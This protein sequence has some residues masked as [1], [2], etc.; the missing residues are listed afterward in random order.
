MIQQII[1]ALVAVVAFGIA[2]KKYLSVYRNIK[3]GKEEKITGD[4]GKRINNT[5]LIALGQK[6]MFKRPLAATMHMFIYVAFIF[7]QIELVE[8]F[9]DGLAGQHRFFYDYLGGFYTL[10]ISFI[11]ILSL[12]ALIATFTFLARRNLLKLPRFVKPEME[13]WPKLDGNLILY[14]EFLLVMFIFLMNSSDMAHHS[15][16]YGFVISNFTYPLFENFS[17]STLHILE[18]IGWW[19]HILIVFAFLNYLPFSKHLHI[20]LA[21]P[22]TYFAKLEKKG[23]MENMPEVQ[24]EVASMF[25]PNAAF[26]EPDLDAPIPKFGASDIFDLSWRH[27][28]GAYTC[29]ECGRCTSMC[30]ANLTGKKLSPRKIMMDTRDRMEEVGKNIETNKTEFIRDDQKE[31]T[32]VLSKENYDDGKN[33]FDYITEE[34]LRACTTCN[35][36]V[37]ACPVMINPLDIIIELRRNLI[38]EQSKSPEEWNSMFNTIENNGAP[39]AFSPDDRDKWIV[40]LLQNEN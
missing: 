2:F 9:V 23:E 35:A 37:E 18:R 19:G 11:E 40:D 28:L 36:C 33:L 38:L 3:L 39:W 14:A 17:D 6:K 5:I 25:D 7:T 34:E 12:G 29:T 31:T 1:F 30:P 21:F 32:S 15:G 4:K 20:M 27:L 22:N 13:G 10:L 16:D 8:I 26:A 24:T